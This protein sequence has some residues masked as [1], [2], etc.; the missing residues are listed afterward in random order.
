M[1]M[2]CEC[3]L[4]PY[5]EL[6]SDGPSNGRRKRG[7]PKETWGKTVEKEMKEQGWTW[8]YLERC[9]ADRPRWRALVAVLM[10][11]TTRRG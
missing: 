8:G 7:R 6:P 3:R 10:R 5:P 11:I 2:F 9:A 1:A 4:Q